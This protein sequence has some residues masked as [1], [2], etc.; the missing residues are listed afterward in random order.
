MFLYF[1]NP[2]RIVPQTQS[3]TMTIDCEKKIMFAMYECMYILGH[4]LKR[5]LYV[6]NVRIYPKY[7]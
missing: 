4:K 1:L 5:F 7:S 2:K 3:T 6:W